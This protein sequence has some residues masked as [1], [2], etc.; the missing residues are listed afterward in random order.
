MANTINPLKPE[1]C[2]CLDKVIES[3]V[4]LREFLQKCQQCELDVNAA[5][6]ENEKHLQ[7]ATAMK[8]AWF[9]DRP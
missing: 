7:T 8:R 6:A 1:D 5:I 3:S 9:P 4:A 2:D